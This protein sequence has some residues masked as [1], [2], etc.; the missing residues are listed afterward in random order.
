[1][2]RLSYEQGD[3]SVLE[4]VRQA[5]RPGTRVPLRPGQHV[6]PGAVRESQRVLREAAARDEPLMQAG[7]HGDDVQLARPP[8]GDGHSVRRGR[9]DRLIGR[10]GTEPVRVLAAQPERA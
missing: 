6:P 1:M 7:H 9:G 3:G 2:S 8:T 5:Q 4:Q 10:A